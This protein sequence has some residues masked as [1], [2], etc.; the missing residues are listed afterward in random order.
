MDGKSCSQTDANSLGKGK[1]RQAI[2]FKNRSKRS[3]PSTTTVVKLINTLQK[4]ACRREQVLAA[5][6]RQQASNKQK[7]GFFPWHSTPSRLGFR[8]LGLRVLGFLFRR[9]LLAPAINIVFS[10]AYAGS[11]LGTLGK[12]YGTRCGAIWNI[13]GNILRTLGSRL[14][15]HF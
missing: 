13:L 6:S 4:L 9:K 12:S 14:A 5:A 10:W 1:E 7:E 11:T 2:F 3:A 15:L 8:I